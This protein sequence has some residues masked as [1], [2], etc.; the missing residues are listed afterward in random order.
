MKSMNVIETTRRQS[1]QI[2]VELI[3][4]CL[5]FLPIS[6]LGFSTLICQM[7]VSIND[8]ACRDAA[9]I[10]AEASDYSAA[11]KRAQAIIVT[12]K[13]SG[14][15]FGPVQLDTS[16]FIFEDYAGTPP[17]NAYP[18]VSVTTTMPCTV[19]AYIRLFG[20]T[21]SEPKS[22]NFRRTYTFPIVK[23]KLYYPAED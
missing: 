1:A 3:V 20:E 5:L 15:M 16:K 12:H 7:A 6:I 10:A 13:T 22:V 11:L 2:A 18:Y 8:R 9:R 23:L 4:A 19:P 14:P 21:V 17:Q